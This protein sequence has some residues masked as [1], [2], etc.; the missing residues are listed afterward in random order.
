MQKVNEIKDKDFLLQLDQYPH[1]NIWTKIISLDWEEDP[2]EEITGR[3]IS[4]NISIDG[5]SAVRRTCS[6]TLSAAEVNINDFY[7]SLNTK[8]QVLIGIEN[9]INL[10]YPEIICIIKLIPDI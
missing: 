5:K 2:I 6:L 1:K 4:G 7:W 10:K 9:H 8:F 3:I